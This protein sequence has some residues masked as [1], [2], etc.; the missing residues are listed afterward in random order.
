MDREEECEKE[1]ERERQTHKRNIRRT[2][3]ER[4]FQNTNGHVCSFVISMDENSIT[5]HT[6]FDGHK[7]DNGQSRGGK[8]NR[9]RV[10]PSTFPFRRYYRRASR[11]S[12][13]ARRR[14]A[15][16]QRFSHSEGAT[17]CA[18]A[19]TWGSR[20]G[21]IPRQSRKRVRAR[22]EG[23]GP[24]WGPRNVGRRLTFSETGD[25]DWRKRRAARARPLQLR[26][27]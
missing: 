10:P 17:R 9:L 7:L 8:C 4:T 11:T 3:R 25:A 18:S 23:S 22:A 19:V 12:F 13:T 2:R 16:V 26:A 20:S 6:T 21:G 27:L 14:R 15:T 1:Y 5:V 24:A